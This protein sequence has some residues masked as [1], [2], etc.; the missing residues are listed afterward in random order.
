MAK[1][2]VMGLQV[3]LPLCKRMQGLSGGS[4]SH[5]APHDADS[6]AGVPEKLASGSQRIITR[7]SN[8]LHSYRRCP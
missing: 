5:L 7:H 2:A 6:A 1:L 4:Q 8:T 3:L